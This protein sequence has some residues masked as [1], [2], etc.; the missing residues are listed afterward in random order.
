MSETLHTL[1]ADQYL[2]FGS[3]SPTFPASLLERKVARYEASLLAYIGGD[4]QSS[5]R[6]AAYRQAHEQAQDQR[7]ETQQAADVLIEGGESQP[8]DFWTRLDADGLSLLQRLS[9]GRSR[10]MLAEAQLQV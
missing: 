9:A 1:E 6:L 3:L 4:D 7:A 10:C 8:P 2:S 5:R